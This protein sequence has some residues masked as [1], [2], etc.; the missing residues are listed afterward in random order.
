MGGEA[1]LEVTGLSCWIMWGSAW[2]ST[3]SEG[4]CFSV[5][6]FGSLLLKA[7]QRGSVVKGGGIPGSRGRRNMCHMFVCMCICK[8]PCE[9]WDCLITPVQLEGFPSVVG[10]GL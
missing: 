2:R 5:F 1:A 6:N 7:R 8:S 9:L 3:D 10:K 4:N